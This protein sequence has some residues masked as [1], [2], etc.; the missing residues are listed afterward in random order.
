L[1]ETHGKVCQELDENATMAHVHFRRTVYKAGGQKAAD[2]VSY[3]TRHPLRELSRGAQ[4]VRYISEGREDCLFTTSKNLP[5]WAEGKPHCFFQAA[6]R[7]ERANGIAFEEWKMTL[8]QELSHRQN[9]DLMHDLM[10]VIAGDEL[11]ITYAF[12]APRTLDGQAQQPHL[13]LLLSARHNDGVARTPEQYFR[14]YNPQHP[15]RGGARKIERLRQFGAVKAHRVLIADVINVHLEQAGCLERVHPE[16]LERRGI[17]RQPEPKLLPS[18]SHAYR[19]DGTVSARMQAVLDVRTARQQT[20]AEEQASARAYWAQREEDLGLTSAMDGAAQLAVIGAARGQAR[21][22][23]STRQVILGEVGMEQDDQRLGDLAGEAYAQAQH[24]ARDV[25]EDAQAA[26]TLRDV[27]REA[28]AQAWQESQG[29]WEDAQAEQERLNDGWA[30]VRTAR[31]DGQA[32]RAAAM[33][34]QHAQ[35]VQTGTWRSLEQDFQALAAQL[36]QFSEESGG[37]GT[38][39]IRLWERDQGLGL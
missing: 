24:E 16:T 30:A 3:L 1:S 5:A 2:R 28:Y 39:R 26:L 23:L 27:G 14:R 35:A 25:W 9:M 17:A 33:S 11:P 18:E 36:D 29:I 4:Q 38:V 12:H 6:E 7:Y 22:Q 37:R 32:A 31:D 19:K 34:A 15:E 13:H 20:R 21:E 10:A 8:P